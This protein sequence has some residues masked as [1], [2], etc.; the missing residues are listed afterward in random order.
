MSSSNTG[1]KWLRLFC[2]CLA[3][4]FVSGLLAL[5]LG[6]YLLGYSEL[7]L[8]K[9]HV[10]VGP[11]EDYRIVV[12]RRYWWGMVPMAPGQGSDAPGVARLVNKQGEV[13]EEVELPM[14]QEAY[15]V[16]WRAGSV[17]I[18]ILADWELP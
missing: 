11:N 7:G 2:K 1:V 13:L 15:E 8:E 14:I 17:T 9:S 3:L 16:E 5:A 18:G 12:L 6:V 4:L 10:D